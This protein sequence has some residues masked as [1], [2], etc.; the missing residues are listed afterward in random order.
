MPAVTLSAERTAPTTATLTIEHWTAA[1]YY[2]GNQTNTT[3]ATVAANTSTTTITNLTVGTGDTYT[4]YSDTN[5]T[6]TLADVTLP[7]VTLSV[8]RTAATAATLTITHWLTQT[9]YYKGDQAN[10]SCR[11]VN[12]NTTT[13][14][15]ADTL[16]ATT[17][18]TYTAY[19]DA[20]C[21]TALA[22]VPLAGRH[23]ECGAHRRY[24]RHPDP[25]RLVETVAV[26][27]RPDQHD[28]LGCGPRRHGHRRSHRPDR[29]DG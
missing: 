26:Q 5:C 16:T 27:G 12:A 17:A 14:S 25:G 4:A 19:S 22:S 1:W 10:A 3:C 7:A 6:T 23:A 11:S 8:E 29:R 24:H 2:K 28:L 20:N 21:T 18:Y 13:V 15:I 9:W